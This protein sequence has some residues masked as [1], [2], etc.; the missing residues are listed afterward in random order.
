MAEEL[1]N[2]EQIEKAKMLFD[3]LSQK[4]ISDEQLK[5]AA[6]MIKKEPELLKNYG[7]VSNI[8]LPDLKTQFEA[9]GDVG[10][11]LYSSQKAQKDLTTLLDNL[12]KIELV[13]HGQTKTIE[14]K[15]RTAANYFLDNAF[16]ENGEIVGTQMVKNIHMMG[17]IIKDKEHPLFADASKEQDT[18]NAIKSHLEQSG[19]FYAGLYT[20]YGANHNSRNF[21]GQKVDELM[22]MCLKIRDNKAIGHTGVKLN[23]TK[24]SAQKRSFMQAPVAAPTT[25]EAAK[26]AQYQGK[27]LTVEQK[28]LLE[29][30]KKEAELA[31]VDENRNKH[32]GRDHKGDKFKD[33]DIIKYMYEDWFLGLMSWGCDKLE[34][35]VDIAL[36]MAGDGIRSLSTRT[37]KKAKETTKP[38][39]KPTLDK[40]T[41]FNNETDGL[42]SNFTSAA[43]SYAQRFINLK[44]DLQNIDFAAITHEQER[45]LR[46]RYGD[47]LISAFKADPKKLDSLKKLSE[48]S[49]EN[50]VGNIK[51]AG[52]C[53]MMLTRLEMVDEMMR[54]DKKWCDSLTGAYLSD[55]ELIAGDKGF[56]ERSQKRMEKIMIALQTLSED[57]RGLAKAEYGKLTTKGEKEAWVKKNISDEYEALINNPETS[58]ERRQSLRKDLVKFEKKY[59]AGMLDEEIYQT[60]SSLKVNTYLDE[61]VQKVQ[62]ATQ[63]QAEFVDN[64]RFDAISRAPNDNVKDI[65][66][67]ADKETEKIIDK[68]VG[69]TKFF[70]KKQAET[71][72]KRTLEEEAISYMTAMPLEVMAE[73]LKNPRGPD[74]V[75]ERKRRVKEAKEKDPLNTSRL[76]SGTTL[77]LMGYDK[78]ER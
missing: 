49:I 25:V 57:A 1:K 58:D 53:A 73:G 75:E 6:E 42:L 70:G 46:E 28:K 37:A 68:G 45:Q 17:T 66:G 21:S 78:K 30:D 26:L 9:N 31:N 52:Q 10:Q 15:P 51:A 8:K 33:E 63:K 11:I 76:F 48:Q 32:L 39:L 36:D 13:Q 4:D 44:K 56:I 60:Y 77:G 35:C 61:M 22:D 55:D 67:E 5:S 54:S 71:P 18:R 74:S 43:P 47:N 19:A 50:I 23:D 3:V 40:T 64:E 65:I 59:K 24:E 62:K 69:Y 29:G 27:P 34:E 2:D 14:G 38:D 16:L 12:A 20:T 7:F 41:S 72:A